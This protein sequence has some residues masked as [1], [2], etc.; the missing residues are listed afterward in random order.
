[1]KRQKMTMKFIP[2]YSKTQEYER[3]YFNIPHEVWNDE[4]FQEF[5]WGV[6]KFYIHLCHLSNKKGN[7]N[8]W[9]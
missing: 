7:N 9:F 8:G 5:S 4:K 2:S 3:P 1:M 6:Q